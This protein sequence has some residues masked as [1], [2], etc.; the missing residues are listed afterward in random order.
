VPRNVLELKQENSAALEGCAFYMP[1]R[2]ECVLYHKWYQEICL[3]LQLQGGAP[4][5][6]RRSH[7]THGAMLN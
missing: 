5:K 2:E 1:K 3:Y 7:V 6:P 4:N